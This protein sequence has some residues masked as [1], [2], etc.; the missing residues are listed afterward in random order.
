MADAL[1]FSFTLLD[2][3][4]GPADTIGKSLRGAEKALKAANIT[5]AATEKALLKTAIDEARAAV[6]TKNLT[7]TLEGLS[8]QLN[9]DK[10]KKLSI[11]MGNFVHS[12]AGFRKTAEGGWIFNVA[13][14]F[15][16]VVGVVERL[17]SG[18]LNVTDRALETAAAG[19]KAK[20]AFGLNLGSEGG[21]SLDRYLGNISQATRGRYTQQQLRDL[22]TP[23][24]S[25]GAGIKDIGLYLPAALSASRRAGGSVE[26]ALG[27]F[28]SIR[29]NRTI[30]AGT[31]SALGFSSVEDLRGITAKLGGGSLSKTNPEAALGFISEQMQYSPAKAQKVIDT[32]LREMAAR[33][34][35]GKLGAVDVGAAG[36]PQDVL[37]RLQNTPA[38]ILEKL[39]AGG[40]LD[41]MIQA[42]DNFADAVSGPKG[43]RFIDALAVIID[44]L[45]NVVDL[46]LKVLGFESDAER[47]R[48]KGGLAIERNGQVVESYDAQETFNLA[49]KAL[50]REGVKFRSITDY[51]KPEIDALALK[52]LRAEDRERKNAGVGTVLANDSKAQDLGKAMG[53]GFFEASVDQDIGKTNGKVIGKANDMVWRGGDGVEIDPNDTVMAFK[54]GGSLG[55]GS[56]GGGAGNV[57]QIMAGAIQVNGAGRNASEIADEVLDRIK[58]QGPAQLFLSQL[59]QFRA[60]V[61]A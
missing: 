52:E 33:E 56:G 24:V 57:L 38:L 10:V 60:E 28:G 61:G 20:R 9:P 19:D 6:E 23:L 49:K 46:A 18:L 40:K 13:E 50:G 16:A 35:G 15:G 27:A 7:K 30:D 58:E 25:Q 54:R 3:M 55:I 47:I 32:I 4:S 21:D 59:E 42:L 44:K 43:Q 2:K 5:M 29:T 48:S 26:G 37:A 8:K 17:G 14:G 53:R 41:G 11:E 36:S 31:L 12:F 45:A 22:V 34:P 51:S 1:R 39:V